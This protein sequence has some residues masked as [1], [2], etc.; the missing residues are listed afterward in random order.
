MKY[1]LVF[2]FLLAGCQVTT[3]HVNLATSDK[4]GAE[5]GKQ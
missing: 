4:A 1:L 3:V 5:I 2:I